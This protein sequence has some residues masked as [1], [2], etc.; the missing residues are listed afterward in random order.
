MRIARR[1]FLGHLLAAA[2]AVAL[3]WELSAQTPLSPYQHKAL[4][5]FNFA[6]YTEW[7]KDAFAGDDAP[8]VLG[9]LGKDP[10]G[11]DLEVIKG[12]TVRGRKLEVKYFSTLEEVSG[13]QLLF[14]ALSETNNLAQILKALENTSVLT[15]AEADGFLQASGMINLVTEKK[16][17]GTQSVAFEVNLAAAQ[18]ANLKLDAQLLKLARNVLRT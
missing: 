10:F 2:L 11:K 6:K 14:I 3:A 15:I 4:Y 18:K 1:Q 16:T 9:I 12:K 7:P 5:L 8:F 13:C 17:A